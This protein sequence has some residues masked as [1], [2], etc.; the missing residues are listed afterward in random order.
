M[1]HDFILTPNYVLVFDCP[2]V[3]DLQ[4][5]MGGGTVLSWKPELGVRIGIMQ[6]SGGEMKWFHT[7]PFSFFILL[8][9]MSKIIKS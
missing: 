4:Q 5:I 1:V 7:E 8:M 9:H 6:R 3:F 2:V